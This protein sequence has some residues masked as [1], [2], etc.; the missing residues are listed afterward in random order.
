MFLKDIKMPDGGIATNKDE[1][2]TQSLIVDAMTCPRKY[3]LSINKISSYEQDKK[4]LFG[5][6]GHDIMADLYKYYDTNNEIPNETALKSIFHKV[7]DGYS[8]KFKRFCI[9]KGRITSAN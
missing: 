7:F 1:G 9:G 8:N 2:I 4:T 6:I 5:S 3:L